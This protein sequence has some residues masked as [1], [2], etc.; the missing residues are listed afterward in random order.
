MQ[1]RRALEQ[2]WLSEAII[3]AV[4]YTCGLL[5]CKVEVKIT[6]RPTARHLNLLMNL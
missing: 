4:N 1:N 3:S 6:H 5:A 2:V